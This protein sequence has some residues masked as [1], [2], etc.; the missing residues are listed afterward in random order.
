MGL[1]NNT[2][3]FY[4]W[5]SLDRLLFNKKP[6]GSFHVRCSDHC[7]RV[8]GYLYFNRRLK[9]GPNSNLHPKSLRQT[10]RSDSSEAGSVEKSIY[11]KEEDR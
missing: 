8:G 11:Q 7:R 5:K 1:S 3:G 6:A 4:Y 10:L 9:R 2:F